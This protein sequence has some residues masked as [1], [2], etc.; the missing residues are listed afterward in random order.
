MVAAAGLILTSSA[1]GS[2]LLAHDTELGLFFREVVDDR[3]EG[4]GYRPGMGARGIGAG[5]GAAAH[6]AAAGSPAA[7]GGGGGS[8]GAAAGGGVR[9]GAPSL[10]SWAP[11]GA[12]RQPQYAAGAAKQE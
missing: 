4:A 1:M 7:G 5:G 3:M 6:Q 8:F 9:E 11:T 10:N 2:A 12:A